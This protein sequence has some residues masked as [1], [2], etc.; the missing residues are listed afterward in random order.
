[1]SNLLDI[2]FQICCENLLV[3]WQATHKYLRSIFF[4]IA[5]LPK[6]SWNWF[7]ETFYMFYIGN[8]EFQQNLVFHKMSKLVINLFF[9][10]DWF[11]T[12]I[13]YQGSK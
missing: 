2:F 9:S 5:Y 7:W 10:I 8:F 3:S 12:T 6:D 11:P 1:M 4:H 13:S